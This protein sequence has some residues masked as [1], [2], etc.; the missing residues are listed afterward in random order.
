[1]R[2]R[3]SSVISTG[4]N[5]RVTQI[6]DLKNELSK[7]SRQCQNKINKQEAQFNSLQNQNAQLKGLLDPK[8][9]VNVRS[10]AVKTSLKVNSQSR[11]KGGT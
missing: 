10:R 5:G 1:M 6:S 4:I 8:L 11:I 7:N 9:L 3:K 2:Q